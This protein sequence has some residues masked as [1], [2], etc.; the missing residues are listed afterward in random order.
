MDEHTLNKVNVFLGQGDICGLQEYIRETTGD[1]S[2]LDV[3]LVIWE[4]EKTKSENTIFCNVFSYSD[5]IRKYKVIANVLQFIVKKQEITPSLESFIQNEISVWA[6]LIWVLGTMQGIDQIHA[7]ETILCFWKSHGYKDQ[8]VIETAYLENVQSL[9]GEAARNE[10]WY[11]AFH[12]QKR[13]PGDSGGNRELSKK[14]SAGIKRIKDNIKSRLFTPTCMESINGKYMIVDCWHDRI[15]YA[16]QLVG[17][18]EWEVLDDNL[19]FPHSICYGS[20][21]YVTENTESGSLCFYR[22]TQNGLCKIDE[23]FHVGERPHRVLY[24]EA[25]K[26]FWGLAGDSQELFGIKLINGTAELFYRHKIKEVPP[27][28]MRGMR[29]IEDSLYIVCGAGACIIKLVCSGDDF[30]VQKIYPAPDACYGMN[31]IIFIGGYFYISVYQD[32]RGDIRPALIKI[33]DLDYFAA[34]EYENIYYKLQMKGV[35]YYFSWIDGKLCIPEIDT[36]SRIVLYDIVDNELRPNQVLYD[37][38]QATGEDIQYMMRHA[39][40]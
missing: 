7:F 23:L 19:R 29:L 9:L 13:L 26:V 36:W 33:K 22:E 5:A 4:L 6:V 2:P 21:I 14:I 27:I 30:T 12:L 17:I 15:I 24:D 18:K 34:G 35:P 40:E 8:N 11:L 20:G 37:C 3:M 1:F 32:N 38:G 16:E 25:R 28:Y 10:E 39:Y 31:D